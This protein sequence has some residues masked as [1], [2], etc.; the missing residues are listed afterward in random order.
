[1]LGAMRVLRVVVTLSLLATS[2]S[3]QRAPSQPR[4][5]PA[6]PAQA[7]P[8][9]AP[10]VTTSPAMTVTDA[11]VPAFKD[12]A[13]R[14]K[15]E[16]AFPA[17]D[18]AIAEEIKKH[19]LP[20]VAVGIV[21]DGE[22]AYGKGF[23]VVSRESK[24]VPD[25]D[26][27]Y[28]IGSITKSFTA[29]GLLAL[30]DE[31]VL[32]LDDP[33]SRWLPEANGFV[34]PT[35]DSPRITLRQLANHTSGLPRMGTI[36]LEAKPTE[37]A[38]V[39]SLAGFALQYAPGTT[40]HYSNIGFGLLGIVL[41]R[42][43]KTSFE[44]V[45]RTRI[46]VPL[47]MTSTVWEHDQVPAGKLAPAYEGTAKGPVVKPVPARLGA[48]AGAGGLYSSVRD[49]AKYVAF[50]MS[51]YPPRSDAD[52]AK[53]KRATLRE[54]HSS[55]IP[56]GFKHEPPA[57]AMSYG[58]GW[59]RFTTCELDDLVGHN[60]GIDSYRSEISFSPSR[61]VGVIMLTNF[62][63]GK[64]DGISEI[65]MAELTKTGALAP[66]F[67]PPSPAVTDAMTRLLTVY[68]QWDEAKLASMLSRPVHPDEQRELAT[69]H[70]LHGACTSFEPKDAAS[71]MAGTFVLK[72]ERGVFEL[73]VS[74]GGKGL[75]DGFAG[76]SRDIKAPPELAKA[77]EAVVALH[78]KWD[79]KIFAKHLAKGPVP[80]AQA[81]KMVED[82]RA[83]HGDCKIAGT[84]HHLFDWGFALTCKK[85]N[86]ELW[87][88]TVPG[89]LT[90]FTGL[91]LRPPRD[92]TKRC[93]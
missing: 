12:P 71:G 9:A 64:A 2:C 8:A 44:D 18:K 32:D 24:A 83:R 62:A 61:G 46:L 74:I 59:S 43:T 15:L 57:M 27:V 38:I 13:R 6:P 41:G 88:Q 81:K 34:Y 1:M 85:E 76:S 28:R 75:I 93:K 31:G 47:N 30:R 53:L 22:L 86:V 36:D 5:A 78:R 49:M 42:A 10:A 65:I 26:T 67:V 69:Y 58:F 11:P 39:D 25:I 90:Q 50:Q 40:F 21:I 19:G 20:G 51:A 3:S 45:L 54:A 79:D 14:Q 33:L 7:L 23:G 48:V 84:L 68:H 37:A 29:L 56:S 4:P 52:G 70:Q 91:Q 92:A 87:V 82:F 80:A 77:A 72:C 63:A 89:D 17:I 16:A 66:R 35:K 55:G 73:E 60:G